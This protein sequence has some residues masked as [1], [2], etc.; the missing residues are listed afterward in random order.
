MNND[1]LERIN[2]YPN[3]L[4]CSIQT[5]NDQNKEEKSQS[6]ILP[7]TEENLE[8]CVILQ[9]KLPYWIFFSVNPMENWKRNMDSVKAIQTWICDIDT[10]SKEEQLELIKNA[11]LQPSLVVES[12]HGFHLY[13]LADSNLTREEFENWN[14]GL[15]NYYN[16]DSKVCKDI[17][18]VLRIPWYYHMKWEKYLV[19]YRKDLSSHDK[20]TMEQITTAFPN[21]LDTTPWR[22]KERDSYN[23]SFNE[24]DNFWSKASELNSRSM[25]EEL[26]WT[27]WLRG[28]TITFKRNSNWTEQIYCNWK[29]TGCWIDN[30]DMIWSWD[31]G[32]PTWIQWLK[33]Y[34]PI[35]WKEL[36]KELKRKYPQLEEKKEERPVEILETKKFEFDITKIP[37]LVKPPFTWGNTELDNELGK[38]NKG[39]LII[40]CWETWAWKTTFATFMARKNDKCCYYVLEDKVENIAM[41]YAMK[42][43]NITKEEFNNGNLGDKEKLFIEWYS[44]FA[45]RNIDMIDIGHKITIDS[46]LQNMDKQVEQGKEIFFID[47]LGFVIGEWQNEAIQTA[48][49]SNKL[50]SYC[51]EKNVCIVLLHHF[52]KRGNA[53]D[54]R[55]IG[56]M[57]GSGKLWDDAFMVVEYLR[58]SWKTF[59][60]VYKDRT[61]GDIALY[62]IGYN[63]GDF[64]FLNKEESW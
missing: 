54:I 32:W 47:N 12:N 56:Q 4:D 20:Y 25:L 7:M 55:D 33:W 16:G 9:Q 58:D 19:K 29:S 22:I 52:K 44:K 38:P 50:V 49:A 51:L 37:R 42:Y 10:G 60:R 8:K 28:D 53:S 39:Q 61:W 24:K 57:R 27:G 31:W 35:D 63:R 64:V 18:R 21:Q 15:K 23:K 45:S 46:L 5:F 11:K 17:A 3:F 36:A 13:Y 1:T 30:K 48:D 59:L 62:E 43:A 6:R 41:R 34:W 26:S 2:T 40:L 14:R